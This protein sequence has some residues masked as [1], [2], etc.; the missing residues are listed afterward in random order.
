MTHTSDSLIRLNISGMSSW[1]LLLE[2]PGSTMLYTACCLAVYLD[3]KI[4]SASIRQFDGI[5]LDILKEHNTYSYKL[6][7]SVIRHSFQRFQSDPHVN[8][9]GKNFSWSWG[10]LALPTYPHVPA[11]QFDSHVLILKSQHQWKV[12]ETKTKSTRSFRWCRWFQ[13]LPWIHERHYGPILQV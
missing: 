11:G 4:L 3:A 10:T 8:C 9:L 1:H 6:I 2:Y 12:V 5:V 13:R 7:F